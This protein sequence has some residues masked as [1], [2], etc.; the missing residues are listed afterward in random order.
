MRCTPA[1]CVI[2]INHLS[3]PQPTSAN[4]SSH[5]EQAFHL[6]MLVEIHEEDGKGNYSLVSTDKDCLKLRIG[7]RKKIVVIVSQNSRHH[8]SLEKYA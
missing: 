8:V 3:I 1:L 5:N 7:T 4:V 6:E 2:D